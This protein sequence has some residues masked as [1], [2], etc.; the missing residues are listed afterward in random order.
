MRVPRDWA[1]TG[2]YFEACSCDAICPCRRVGEA[3]GGRPTYGVCD[4]AL[5]W[6]IEH[7]H[8][9]GLDLAGLEVVMA[10]SFD[11]DEPG[12]T[13]RVILYVDDGA[14]EAQHEALE[15]IYLGRAGGSTLENFARF[16]GEVHAV[17]RAAISIEHT[18]DRR[19][20]AAGGWVTVRERGP[21]K[22]AE[23]V[24]CGIPGH[25]HPG[26]EVVAET[27]TVDDAPLRF[28]VSGRCGFA[29]VFTYSS[30]ANAAETGTSTRARAGTGVH[31]S[32]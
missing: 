31:W 2:A 5:G 7:G 9:D 22:T 8:A 1:V 19:S 21:V 13:W 14:T 10:G 15:A 18:P 24:S 20:I 6:T 29:S 16:I 30:T 25:E 3:P 4:F 11:D 12:S 17:H 27:L 26:T 32:S 28:E 23:I